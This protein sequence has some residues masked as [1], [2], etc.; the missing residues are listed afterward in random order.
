VIRRLPRRAGRARR[1]GK[2]INEA[3]TYRNQ[4]LPAGGEAESII[5]RGEPIRPRSL[6]GER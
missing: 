3:N 5:Q 4:V 6:P 2:S 1:Q